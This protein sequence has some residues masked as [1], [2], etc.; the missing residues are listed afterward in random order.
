MTLQKTEE[1]KKNPVID[2]IQ[3]MEDGA[4]YDL[5]I[6]VSGK[7]T[8]GHYKNVSTADP[9]DATGFKFRVFKDS[10]L[11]TIENLDYGWLQEC[12][13]RDDLGNVYDTEVRCR[14]GY[15]FTADPS[16]SK[17]LPINF[18][19]AEDAVAAGLKWLQD[20]ELKREV[21]NENHKV[22]RRRTW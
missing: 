13:V 9:T 5:R 1:H 3:N 2:L 12:Q 21:L 6:S 22:R 4:D 7:L 18:R 8:A 11:F 15:P 19:T 14:Q 16:D 17:S 10:G 20:M